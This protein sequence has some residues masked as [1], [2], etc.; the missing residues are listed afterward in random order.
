ML[1]LIEDLGYPVL[2]LRTI[3]VLTQQRSAF[4]STIEAAIILRSVIHFPWYQKLPEKITGN[5]NDHDGTQYHQ[6]IFFDPFRPLS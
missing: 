5:Q 4:W 1:R 2:S 6:G 3:N